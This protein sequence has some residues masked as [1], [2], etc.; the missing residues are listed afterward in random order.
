VG[1]EY[2]L[3]LLGLCGSGSLIPVA[4]ELSFETVAYRLSPHC[5]FLVFRKQDQPFLIEAELIPARAGHRAHLG[6]L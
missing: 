2:R 6:Y 3:A 5:Q 4:G 1:Q